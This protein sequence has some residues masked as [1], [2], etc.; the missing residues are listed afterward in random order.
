[1]GALSC[2]FIR[3][4]ARER[5]EVMISMC[6]FGKL[7]FAGKNNTALAAKRFKSVLDHTCLKAIMSRFHDFN[8][9]GGAFVRMMDD[10]VHFER[11]CIV[12]IFADLPA[13]TKLTLTGS[14]CN[15]C[16]LPRNRMAEMGASAPLRT[17]DNMTERK[18]TFLGRMAGGETTTTVIKDAKKVGVDCYVQSAF[19]IPRSGINP[20][21]PCPNLDNPWNCTPPV[22]L[23]GMEMGTLMKSCE[24]TMHFIVERSAMHNIQAATACRAVDRYCAKV[25]VAQCRN[26]NVEIG[27]MA[28]LPQ[29]HGITHH[30][31]SGKAKDGHQRSS[32]G[33]LMHL[34]IA[35]CELFTVHERIQHCK[36]YDIVW[37]CR[38]QMSWP[39]HRD[40]LAHVQDRL[41]QMDQNLIRYM[42]PFS[43]SQCQSEKHHQW[44]HYSHHRL[45][46]GCAAKE[47]AFERSYAVGHKKQLQFTNKSKTKALQTSAKHYFRN[48]VR[49]L[50]GHLRV[51]G[52]DDEPTP[53]IRTAHLENA[54]PFRKY[55]L[56][57]NTRALAIMKHKADTMDLPLITA[58]STLRMTLKNRMTLPGKPGRLVPVIFRAIHNTKDPWV[59]NIRVHYT[60]DEDRPRVG[61]G[62]CLG[63]FGDTEGNFHVAMQWYK[64]CGR[65]PL[66]RIARMS[67]VELTELYDYVPV[68]SI[69]NGALMVPMAIEPLI[70][71]PQ[72]WWVIQSH[73]EGIALE[74]MNS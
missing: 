55:N 64:I 24:G 27:P 15:T 36:L 12:G 44:A 7:V 56:N 63:F 34:Y 48:G 9:R 40:N 39:V 17:W 3:G 8:R 53:L 13:A 32:L 29:P 35:T 14:S 20:I 11:A 67:K 72:Q 51:G 61:F 6:T 30:I 31:M 46:T 68:G 54:M 59:D 57:V 49:R 60:D 18:N 62:K 22:F 4:K 23:H 69:L 74:R 38:E 70:G 33:R 21:G 50:A 43:K 47:Y 2:A 10:I 52:C 71:Y 5:D 16:Y 73:R 45:N 65:L 41:D 19:A 37:E 66:D 42:L 58:S 25:Y 1:V 26:S 28:L